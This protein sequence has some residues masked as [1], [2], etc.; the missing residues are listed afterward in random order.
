MDL[1]YCPVSLRPV[2]GSQFQGKNAFFKDLT[3][4]Q[5]L[6]SGDMDPEVLS[7]RQQVGR[8]FVLKVLDLVANNLEVTCDFCFAVLAQ[9]RDCGGSNT[10]FITEGQRSLRRGIFSFWK[11]EEL[12]NSGCRPGSVSSDLWGSSQKALCLWAVQLWDGSSW[13]RGKNSL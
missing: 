9:S 4:I 10:V 11:G 1:L 3:S 12:A 7:I 2:F 8:S 5:L 6:P 13:W